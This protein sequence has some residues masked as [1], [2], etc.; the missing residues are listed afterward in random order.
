MLT[1]III[2]LC[3]AKGIV[4][5]GVSCECISLMYKALG[6]SPDFSF[7]HCMPIFS[8]FVSFVHLYIYDCCSV[9]TVVWHVVHCPWLQAGSICWYWFGGCSIVLVMLLSAAWCWMFLIVI[10]SVFWHAVLVHKMSEMF[11]H[12]GN[13]DK[14]FLYTEQLQTSNLIIKLLNYWGLYMYSKS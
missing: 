11:P 2:S 14:Q 5:S 6:W 8:C 1:S 3:V 13:T 4:H 12:C 10:W 7:N 9:V